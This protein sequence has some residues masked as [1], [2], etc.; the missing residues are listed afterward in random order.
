MTVESL[1]KPRRVGGSLVVTIP[2]EVVDEENIHEGEIVTLTVRKGK[3]SFLG[4]FKWFESMTREDE[5]D[6]HD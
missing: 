3:K 5:F 1:V 6:V 2:K 4:A